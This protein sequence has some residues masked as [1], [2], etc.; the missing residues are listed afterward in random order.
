MD[1]LMLKVFNFLVIP[2][3]SLSIVFFVLFALC[4]L[5]GVLKVVDCKHSLQDFHD[6]GLANY[7]QEMYR[8]NQRQF[9]NKFIA[10]LSAK[11]VKVTDLP[12]IF[13]SIGILGTFLGLGVAI[14]GAADLLNADKVDLMQLNSV[15]SV[16]AFKFQTSVWGTC[17]SLIFQ[18]FVLEPYFVHK[19][20]QL[21]EVETAIYADAVNQSTAMQWQLAELQGMHAALANESDTVRS[22][23]QNL[24]DALQNQSKSLSEMAEKMNLSRLEDSARQLKEF[25]EVADNMVLQ[26]RALTDTMNTQNLANNSKM[27]EELLGKV[28]ELVGDERKNNVLSIKELLTKINTLV[29]DSNDSNMKIASELLK[30][31]DSMVGDVNESNLSTIQ[32][33]LQKINGLIS[34]SS[35]SN[36]NL[37]QELLAQVTKLVEETSKNSSMNLRELLGKVTQLV[38]D[39]NINNAQI[40]RELLSKVDTLV[41]DQK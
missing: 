30:K 27:M 41:S 9:M 38:G 22:S 10:A 11:E 37:V 17:F 39:T 21:G 24:V 3:S 14:H 36:A 18:K 35:D 26:Q 33:L 28:S 1:D 12:N 15:L 31:V 4:F 16:I 20:E 13:V 5:Y 8:L 7:Q 23:G 34:Q 32:E 25:K 29:G 19:Q 2:E 6:N 40:S